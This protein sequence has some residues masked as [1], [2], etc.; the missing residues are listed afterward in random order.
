MTV[1][2]YSALGTPPDKQ[3]NGVTAHAHRRIMRYHWNNP[4]IVGQDP[5][6]LSLHVSGRSDLQYGVTR[7][8]CVI[9]RDESWS[10]GFYEA[11]VDNSVVGP[12][13]A[14][15]ATHPRV[16]VIWIRANDLDFDDRPEGTAADGS[17]LPPT[18]R[19]E[20]GVTQGTP[21]ASPAEPA[22][23]ARAWRLGAMLMPA[24]A[25]STASATQYGEIDY[26][27][28]YGS[29]MGIIAKV[30]ENKDQQASSNPPYKNPILNHTAYFPT[31]RNILLRAYLCVS[32]PKKTQVGTTRGVAAVQFY[33][34]GQKYMTRKV[35]YS[36]AW[37]THEVTASI[38]VSAGRHTF[39]LAMYNEQGGG[40]VTHYSNNDPDDRGNYYVGRVLVIKDEGIA[41]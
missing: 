7:G 27:M 15:D 35:E 19:I 31:D 14:G 10:E 8:L 21:A 39:G 32:A 17:L 20:L 11:Y 3:H 18:N 4:G 29:E 34:D 2:T 26:A 25:T 41:R 36:E 6:D 30:A 5:Q 9:P 33:L 37:V 24:G 13:A 23:P 12:V 28:P 16:D 22:I 38:E 1:T 40:Y